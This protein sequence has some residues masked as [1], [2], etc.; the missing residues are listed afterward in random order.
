[1][2]GAFSLLMQSGFEG[3]RLYSPRRAEKLAECLSTSGFVTGHGFTRR[4]ERKNSQNVFQQAV[5]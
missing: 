5:L 1:M 2:P 4:G 3:A